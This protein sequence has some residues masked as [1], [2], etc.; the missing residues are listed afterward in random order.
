MPS[1]KTIQPFVTQGVANKEKTYTF[2]AMAV[3]TDPKE[4]IGIDLSPAARQI[5]DSVRE[6]TGVPK[7][8]AL[9]RIL[10]WYATLEPRFQ[11]AILNKDESVRADLIRSIIRDYAGA[12]MPADPIRAASTMDHAE[13]VKVAKVMLDTL[14]V[15]YK[16]AEANL[17]TQRS[18]ALK[19]ASKK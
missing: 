11:L 9:E 10:E 19:A 17:K 1:L 16:Q 12:D 6:R 13:A 4:R 3:A 7:V 2:L 5:V 14:D 18:A 8:A 15:L